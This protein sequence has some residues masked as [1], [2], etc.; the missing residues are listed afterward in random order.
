[1]TELQIYDKDGLFHN[2]VKASS[3]LAGRYN[4]L[5]YGASDLNANNVLTGIELPKDTYP[6]AV[7]LPPVSSVPGTTQSN[8]GERFVFRM[9][10][11]CKSFY[12]GDNKIKSPDPNTNTSMHTIPMD[13]NDM[14]NTAMG[15]MNSLE[16]LIPILT[17]DFIIEQR[18]DWII[19]R[20]SN[21]GV[22]GVSGVML[23]FYGAIGLACEYPDY[24]VSVITLPMEEHEPHFH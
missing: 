21:K 18:K 15:F 13:W 24:D 12:S 3:I 7:C 16:Q 8:I 20:I 4:I 1:M 22:D 14:K 9:L 19:N 5:P 6:L 11:L 2:I 10:F 17:G 23:T